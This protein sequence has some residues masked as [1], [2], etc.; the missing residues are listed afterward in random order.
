MGLVRRA[1]L[2]GVVTVVAVGLSTACVVVERSEP[3]GRTEAPP[4]GEPP[5]PGGGNEAAIARAVFDMANRER[6][7]RGLKPLQWDDELAERARA[8]SGEM[9]RRGRLQHQDLEAMR[10]DVEG[11]A[12]LGENVFRSTAAVPAGTIHVGWMRSDGHRANLLR[13]AFDRLGVGVLCT[14]EGEVWATQRFGATEL[15]GRP[16]DGEPPP[17]QPIV[18]DDDQGPT[19]AGSAAG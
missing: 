2:L 8:W 14:E 4:P 13:P 10:Q 1:A 5:D 16:S 3:D 18:V 9:S 15:D 7:E 19:C 11:Y 12:G 6:A 17:E